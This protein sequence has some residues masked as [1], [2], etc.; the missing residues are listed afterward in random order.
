VRFHCSDLSGLPAP[1]SIDSTEDTPPSKMKTVIT[2]NLCQDL[3]KESG[4]ESDQCPKGTRV[5]MKVINEKDGEDR[6]VQVIPAGGSESG[7]WPWSAELGERL[8]GAERECPV[9][10]RNFGSSFIDCNILQGHWS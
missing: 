8:E 9:W 10:R 2:L 3:E 6:L 5:C 1:V 4:P 7:D